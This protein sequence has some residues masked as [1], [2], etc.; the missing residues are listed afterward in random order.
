VT[1]EIE[2]VRSAILADQ[3]ALVAAL[4][5]S[6][7]LSTIIEWWALLLVVLT[8]ITGFLAKKTVEL[9]CVPPWVTALWVTRS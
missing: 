8:V 4:Q 9:G 5:R 7:E 1:T 3:A 2:Q 6:A